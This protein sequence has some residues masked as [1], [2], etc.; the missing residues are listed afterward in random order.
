MIKAYYSIYI[1]LTKKRIN[2]FVT[3]SITDQFVHG[4][5]GINLM[6]SDHLHLKDYFSDLKK[7]G[8][9]VNMIHAQF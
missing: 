4:K 9:K 2:R 1:M 5:R 8:L 3:E 7:A 6:K